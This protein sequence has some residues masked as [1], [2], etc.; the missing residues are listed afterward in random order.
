MKLLAII[1]IFIGGLELSNNHYIDD[2]KV[3]RYSYVVYNKPYR[4]TMGSNAQ[5]WIKE[6][7]K[8]EG[9]IN[10]IGEE[11]ALIYLLSKVNNYN[12]LKFRGN[13]IVIYGRCDE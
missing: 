4:I 12:G 5:L 9:F 6:Y 1:L 2:N 3:E 10:G 13:C 11:P 8:G 7:S